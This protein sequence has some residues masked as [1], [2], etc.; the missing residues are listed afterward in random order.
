VRYFRSLLVSVKTKTSTV[1]QEERNYINSQA[2]LIQL[3]SDGEFYENSKQVVCKTFVERKNLD[4][5]KSCGVVLIYSRGKNAQHTLLSI[6]NTLGNSDFY[7]NMP[8]LHLLDPGSKK[9]MIELHAKTD[10]PDLTPI[11]K[12]LSD[13]ESLS[14]MSQN[15]YNNRFCLQD[16]LIYSDE[17]DDEVDCI[18]AVAHSLPHPTH[19]DMEEHFTCFAPAAGK[20]GQ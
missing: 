5:E 11:E 8:I 13:F 3:N 10:T 18:V 20:A 19:F 4:A 1:K 14:C 15:E 6:I 2:Q 7:T 16:L 12:L 9:E 17:Y